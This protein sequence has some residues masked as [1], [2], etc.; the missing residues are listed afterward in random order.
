MTLKKT[1]KF[2]FDNKILLVEDEVIISLDLKLLLKHNNYIISSDVSTGEALLSQFQK[3]K[4]DLIILDFNLGGKIQG[5]DAVVEIRKHNNTPII[6]LS[7]S[8][9]AKMQKF[10]ADFYNIKTL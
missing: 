4:P 10:A 2:I 5:K 6:L 1:K 7:G 9:R 8:S 3:N